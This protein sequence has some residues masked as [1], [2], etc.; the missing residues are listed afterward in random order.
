MVSS[1]PYSKEDNIIIAD[2]SHLSLCLVYDK[3]LIPVSLVY[4]ACRE[5]TLLGLKCGGE[6]WSPHHTE[7]IRK[8]IGV[9]NSTKKD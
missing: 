4:S 2:L 1:F 3:V 9:V 5:V 6:T 7:M 8:H